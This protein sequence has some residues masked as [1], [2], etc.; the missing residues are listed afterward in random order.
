MELKSILSFDK[1]VYPYCVDEV[2]SV[3]GWINTC[4]IQTNILFIGINDGSCSYCLQVVSEFSK[5]EKELNSELLSKIQRGASVKVTGKL[6]KS[7][8]N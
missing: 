5:E 2:I 3:K 6:I 8:I 1:N 4:R 7:I